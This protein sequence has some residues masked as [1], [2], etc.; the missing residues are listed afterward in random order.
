MRV[1][2]FYD[3]MRA[4]AEFLNCSHNTIKKYGKTPKILKKKYLIKI[5]SQLIPDTK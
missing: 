5:F 4:A 1:T 2:I 3:F